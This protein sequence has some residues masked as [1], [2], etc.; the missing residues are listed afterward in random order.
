[1][2]NSQRAGR[3]EDARSCAA[4][5]VPTR[6]LRATDALQ[7]QR[8]ARAGDTRVTF[9][10]T[11]V[12][13]ARDYWRRNI[14]L[15][16]AASL[17]AGPRAPLSQTP[18]VRN[19]DPD[20]VTAS[21][22]HVS[23]ELRIGPKEFVRS[24]RIIRFLKNCSASSRKGPDSC[25]SRSS[26]CQRKLRADSCRRMDAITGQREPDGPPGSLSCAFSLPSC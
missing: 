18:R 2:V 21:R 24:V 9:W 5:S 11:L 14:R 1:M 23:I 12:I 17:S 4:G 26:R 16:C 3:H 13:S 25:V 19:L 8:S 15:L 10:G 7:S 20:Q 22:L 6:R